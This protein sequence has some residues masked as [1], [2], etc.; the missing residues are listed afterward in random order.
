MSLSNF[1]KRVLWDKAI[2][3]ETHYFYPSSLHF[4][5]NNLS[6]ARILSFEYPALKREIEVSLAS[7]PTFF[8][9][10][11]TTTAISFAI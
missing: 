7:F 2:L 5:G 4:G 3:V 10:F 9:L 1:F 6:A 11:I 8:Q